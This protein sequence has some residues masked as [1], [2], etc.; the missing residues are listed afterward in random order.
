[1]TSLMSNTYLYDRE[2]D[3]LEHVVTGFIGVFDSRKRALN[4]WN[5]TLVELCVPKER[6]YEYQPLEGI[7]NRFVLL[8]IDG[9]MTDKGEDVDFVIELMIK[10]SELNEVLKNE[11]AE[12]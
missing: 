4:V 7:S 11:F 1:M 8:D 9:K 3:K 10:D 2:K 6:I 12:A 5:D